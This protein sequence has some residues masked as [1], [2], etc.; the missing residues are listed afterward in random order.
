[1]SKV[2][3]DE[4]KLEELTSKRNLLFAQLSKNPSDTR[5]ALE[6]KVLDDEIMQLRIRSRRFAKD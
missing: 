2:Q 1:V 5:P 6:I 3:I 4:E